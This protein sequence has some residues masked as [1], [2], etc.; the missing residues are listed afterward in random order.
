M[1]PIVSATLLRTQSDVRLVAL[2]RQ[3]HERAF[4]A[5]VERYR[6]PLHRYLRRLL[7]ESRAEDALQQTYMKAWSALQDGIEVLDLK[8]W[9]YRIA[10]NTA[11]DALKKAGYDY[12]ELTESLHAPGAP[13]A[14]VERRVVI[15]ETLAGVAALPYNQRE[16]LLRTA[17]EGHSRA[18]VASDLGVSDGAVRQLLHRARTTLRAAATAATPMPIA[19]W[20]AGAAGHGG[21]TA[22]RVGELVAGGGAGLLLKGGA[23]LVAAGALVTAPVAL[24]GG[25]TGHDPAA[26]A[27]ASAPASDS[28]RPAPAADR[29]FG[30]SGGGGGASTADRGGS[31]G[32]HGGGSTSS[33]RSGDRTLPGGDRRDSSGG[34]DRRGSGTSG[35]DRSGAGRPAAGDDHSASGIPA[36]GGGGPRP[37]G[38]DPPESGSP[39][40]ATPSPPVPS[41]PVPSADSSGRSRGGDGLPELSD[42]TH[43]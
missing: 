15:R 36:D 17:V 20:A 19:G 9:L 6:R 22:E 3:G 13:E 31:D 25:S 33:R 27:A 43:D 4:E 5:M 16:A 2:A 8:P 37:E 32:R 40:A 42:P 29:A 34:D 7:N 11:L 23:V 30:I 38:S 21:P 35:D 28:D 12:D 41:P 18:Q 10:R 26:A 1:T 39:S 24:H 14:D